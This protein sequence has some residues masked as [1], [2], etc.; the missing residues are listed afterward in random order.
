MV[1]EH[2]HLSIKIKERGAYKLSSVLLA[3]G[4]L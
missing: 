3:S 1:I 2:G 4:V